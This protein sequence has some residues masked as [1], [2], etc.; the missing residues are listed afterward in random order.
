MILSIIGTWI[1]Q[2]PLAYFLPKITGWGVYG[3]RWAI[4][5]TAFLLTVSYILY[6]LSGR[7]KRKVV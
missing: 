6:F 5:I 1:V 4:V 3:V 2:I 7:W